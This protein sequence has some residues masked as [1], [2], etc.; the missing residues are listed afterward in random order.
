[1]ECS[2]CGAQLKQLL[3]SYYCPNEEQHDV[4]N[5]AQPTPNFKTGDRVKV[6][7]YKDSYTWFFRGKPAKITRRLAGK[8]WWIELEDGDG[9]AP[10]KEEDLAHYQ[11]D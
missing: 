6:V 9:F 8:T 10:F 11:N 2:H 3:T 5:I 7:S 1:M 4:N